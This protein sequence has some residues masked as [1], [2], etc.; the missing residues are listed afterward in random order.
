MIKKIFISL[1]WYWCL[2]FILLKKNYKKKPR[3]QRS[4]I[5][6]FIFVSSRNIYL[7]SPK[8]KVFYWPN[9]IFSIFS[10]RKKISLDKIEGKKMEKQVGNEYWEKRKRAGKED[11]LSLSTVYTRSDCSQIPKLDWSFQPQGYR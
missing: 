2:L 6:M 1:K 4:L 10:R 7:F 11:W 3:E 9:T 5:L 8:K